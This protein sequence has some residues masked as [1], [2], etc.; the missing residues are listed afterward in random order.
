[1][2]TAIS[3]ICYV[4]L[5][6]LYP[7]DESGRPVGVGSVTDHKAENVTFYC[8]V[9]REIG[10]FPQGVVVGTEI[11]HEAEEAMESVS[12]PQEEVPEN[13]IDVF[14]Q[15]NNKLSVIIFLVYRY[16]TYSQLL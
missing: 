3:V 14:L 4:V 8:E 15:R 1:M 7:N 16:M 9:V 13:A 5:C 11:V 10:I 2:E 6:C 12:V